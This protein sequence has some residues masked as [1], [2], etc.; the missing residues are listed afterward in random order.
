MIERMFRRTVYVAE[1]TYR[2]K[3]GSAS[4]ARR[5]LAIKFEH[6]AGRFPLWLTPEQAI[7]LPISDK[8]VEA[9]QSMSRTLEELGIRTSVDERNEK[10]GRKIRD[11]ELSKAPYMLVL[12]EKEVADAT[13]SVREHGKGDIG[14][15]SAE[16]F[17]KLVDAQIAVQLGLS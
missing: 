16:A 13:I 3:L 9:A 14:A 6:T 7:I 17:A 10:I 15:M 11:A 5:T 4:L 12:G 8:F 2:Q 1:C